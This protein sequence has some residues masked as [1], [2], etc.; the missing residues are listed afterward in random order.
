MAIIRKKDI[1]GLSKKELEER[2]NDLNLEILKAKSKKGQAAAGTKNVRE[3]K[4]TI[5]RAHTYLKE[6]K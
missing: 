4:K 2:I 1:K 6:I 3:I 5:A